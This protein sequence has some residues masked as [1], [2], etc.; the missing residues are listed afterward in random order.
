MQPRRKKFQTGCVFLDAKSKTWFFRYYVD[1]KRRAERIGTK[2]TVAAGLSVACVGFV[3]ISY[4]VAMLQPSNVSLGV[5]SVEWLRNHGMAWL[6]NDVENVYYSL[7]APK[8]G[9][10]P[11]KALPHV[12]VAAAGVRGIAYQP[13]PIAPVIHP[14][15]P[16]E[17]RVRHRDVGHREEL[18][19]FPRHPSRPGG[20]AP[21][22]C[23]HPPGT[24]P[25]S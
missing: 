13:P 23:P 24:Q 17:G 10:K 22:D 11:L 16:G 19:G 4:A 5:R 21:G 1:G 14:A 2:Q 6:V 7:N 12:G 8:K 9:G 20:Q 3:L 25:V 15:L 18:P